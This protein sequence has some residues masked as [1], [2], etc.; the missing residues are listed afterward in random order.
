M[1]AAQSCEIVWDSIYCNPPGFS[2]HGVLQARILELP[3]LSPGDLPDPGIKPMSPSLQAGSLPSESSAKPICSPLG[4]RFCDCQ[5]THEDRASEKSSNLPKATQLWSNNASRGDRD[6]KPTLACQI[7][8]HSEAVERSSKLSECS[9]RVKLS[10]TP[11]T[12]QLIPESGLLSASSHPST[13]STL[14]IL[15]SQWA[16]VGRRQKQ[17]WRTRERRKRGKDHKEEMEGKWLFTQQ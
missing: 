5:F 12:S 1:L 16:P 13:R 7:S 11:K 17:R 10:T 9:P 14:Q 6:S 4:G 8:R 2:V 3:F 15:G